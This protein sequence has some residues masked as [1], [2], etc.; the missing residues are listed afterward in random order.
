MLHR[1]PDHMAIVVD[2]FGE[3]SG[4]VTNEDLIETLLGL[5]IMDE[6]DETKDLRDLARKQWKDRA[7]KM[8]IQLPE[9]DLEGKKES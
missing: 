9:P 6:M 8:G 1:R 5:E 4:V 3:M 2:E 7:A